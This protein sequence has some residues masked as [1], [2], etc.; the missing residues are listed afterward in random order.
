[1]STSLWQKIQQEAT[2]V[3]GEEPVLASFL[4]VTLLKH[5][6]ML[7]A[8]G[9]LLAI[10]VIRLARTS[11]PRSSTTRDFTPCRRGALLIGCGSG[12]ENPWR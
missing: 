4:Q 8:L 1:M 2:V 9:F 12:T 5:D 6:S 11:S 7:A 10:S 3:A